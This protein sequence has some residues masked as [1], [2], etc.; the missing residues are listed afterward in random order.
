GFVAGAVRVSLRGSSRRLEE[1]RRPPRRRRPE[2]SVLFS[3]IGLQFVMVSLQYRRERRWQCKF[4]TRIAANL[5][6]GGADACTS[7][8]RHCAEVVK[9]LRQSIQRRRRGW[10]SS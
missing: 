4:P 9:G 6:N 7:D 1:R 10:P 2:R 3:F 5:T 8:G